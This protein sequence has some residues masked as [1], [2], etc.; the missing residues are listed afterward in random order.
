M[1][2]YSST[3]DQMATFLHDIPERSQQD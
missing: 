1:Q 3:E 2:P